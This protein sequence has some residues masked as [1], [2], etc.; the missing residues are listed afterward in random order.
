LS[1]IENI[2]SSADIKKLNSAELIELCDE[3]RRFEVENIA[4]TGGHLASNLGTVELTV[5]IHRVYDTSKDRLV[6]DVGH[7]CYTHKIITGRREAFHTLRQRGGISGFP[8]PNEAVDDAFIAGHAS[9]SVSAALGMAKAR[10]LLGA[11]YDVVALIGDG[12]LTG[13]LSYEGLCNAAAS[14]EPLVII[15]NDNN[16][17]ISENVG[18]TAQ[19]LQALRIKPGYINFKKWFRSVSSHTRWV[20]D[21]V[22]RTK[23]RL[24]SWILPSNVFSDMGLYYLGPVDGHNLEKL[25]NAIRLAKDLRRPVLLHVLTKKG[26]GCSYAEAHPDKYH[27]VGRFDPETGELASVGPSFSDKIGDFLCQYAELDNRIVAITAAMAGGT[28][29]ECFAAKFPNRF[30]D[31]GIAEEHAVIMAAAMAKQGLVPVFAVYS[32]FLQRSFDM[33]IHDVSLL[34]LHVVLCVDRAGLVGSDGETHQGLFDIAYLGS[35]PGMTVLC[36]ASFSELHDMLGYALHNVSG[37]VAV[38]YPR[39]GEGRYTD[40]VL[41]AETVLREGSDLTVVCYGTMINEVLDAADKLAVQGISTEIVKLGIVFPNEYELC[42][43]SLRKTGRLLAAEEV[44]AAG[45]VGRRLL[46]AC[47]ENDLRL[48]AAKLMNLGDGIITHGTVE[49]LRH[50]FGI[51]SDA[52]V[53]AAAELCGCDLEKE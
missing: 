43:R 23:E 47:A 16:M 31:V 50:D 40:C 2:N 27:G 8:K 26:K 1:I 28:G 6:L 46:S 42:L 41:R 3:L 33:L 12:A 48:S 19:L 29:T 30:F 13:G 18:G 4:R 14:N 9:A 17:S 7:Q 49:E 38:R 21:F 51:D 34:G 5:A 11:D 25:E 35:V 32:S 24:K 53:R 22:H 37:P 36:P 45:C 15:L 52:I 39:G 44:C 10:T 20:Y